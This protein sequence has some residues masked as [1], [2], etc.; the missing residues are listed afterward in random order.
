MLPCIVA[1]CPVHQYMGVDPHHLRSGPAGEDRR[2]TGHRAADRW[3]LPLCRTHHDEIER[4]G[5]RGERELFDAWGLNPYF[6][7]MA[8]WKASRGQKNDER[9]FDDM[10]AL[11]HQYRQVQ[12]DVR[13]ARD[14]AA[15]QRERRGL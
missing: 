6:P 13:A 7:T 8:L 11:V 15:R 5:T 4:A 14:Y 9:A 10:L 3:A 2:R 1:G 12:I